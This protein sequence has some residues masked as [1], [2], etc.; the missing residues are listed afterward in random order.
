ML[1]NFLLALGA[2]C[3]FGCGMCYGVDYHLADVKKDGKIIKRYQ[4]CFI[5]GAVWLK[6]PAGCTYE[7]DKCNETSEVYESYEKPLKKSLD[8]Y[9]RSKGYTYKMYPSS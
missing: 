3:L 4:C 5:G 2:L 1:R 8:E 6:I 9:C 7:Y